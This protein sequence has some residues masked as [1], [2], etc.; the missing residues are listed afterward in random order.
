[1]GYPAVAVGLR[2][3]QN[4]PLHPVSVPTN[5]QILW[6]Y[7]ARSVEALAFVSMR[8]SARCWSVEGAASVFTEFSLSVFEK[9]APSGMRSSWTGSADAG[10]PG[11]DSGTQLE[12][13]E[14]EAAAVGPGAGE[15][16]RSCVLRATSNAQEFGGSA[17]ALLHSEGQLMDTLHVIGSGGGMLRHG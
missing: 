14:V 16:D 4:L 11:A 1:M 3:S 7:S 15:R 17:L 2:G 10:L 8:G 5:R 12:A 9:V 13:A 6:A